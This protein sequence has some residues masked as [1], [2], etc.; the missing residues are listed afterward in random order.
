MKAALL[1]NLPDGVRERLDKLAAYYG[2]PADLLAQKWVVD[3]TNNVYANEVLA[4]EKA[5][6]EAHP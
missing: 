3:V 1:L 6:R 4:L 2:I 5:E